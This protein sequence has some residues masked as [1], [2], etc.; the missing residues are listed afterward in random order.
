MIL[1]WKSTYTTLYRWADGPAATQGRPTD[2]RF[3]GAQCSA[4]PLYYTYIG[5]GST[6]V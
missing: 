5:V 4:A 6:P 1:V 3:T 2:D